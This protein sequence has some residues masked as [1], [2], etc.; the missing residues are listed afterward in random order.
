[1]DYDKMTNEELYQELKS[2]FYTVLFQP[3]SDEN[4]EMVIGV[5]KAYDRIHD[6]ERR[7]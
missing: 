1:M 7:K 4:R 2:A 5:L 6:P 3:V